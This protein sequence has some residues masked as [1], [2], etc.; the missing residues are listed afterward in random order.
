MFWQARAGGYVYTRGSVW[1]AQGRVGIRSGWDQIAKLEQGVQDCI[2][3]ADNL[4]PPIDLDISGRS[5]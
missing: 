4:S 3:R 5:V 2:R 1:R